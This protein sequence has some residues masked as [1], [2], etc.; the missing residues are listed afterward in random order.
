MRG[1]GVGEA[2]FLD[3]LGE[4]AAQGE[5][6]AEEDAGGPGADCDEEEEGLDCFEAGGVGVGAV[7]WLVCLFYPP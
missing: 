6:F 7:R 5:G 1:R 2:G 4:P 3:E